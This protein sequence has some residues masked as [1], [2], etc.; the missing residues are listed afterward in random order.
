MIC[1][2]CGNKTQVTNSRIQKRLNRIWRRRRCLVC[3]AIFTTEEM[4]DLRTSLSVRCANGPVAPF[5]RDKL[6]I[7]I[8]RS[9]GHRTSSIDDAG[10]LTATVIAILLHDATTA[11]IGPADIIR[12][13][14]ATLHRFDNVAAV[15]YQAY[16][17]Q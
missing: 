6:F 17:R 3:N 15:Q 1:I 4:A 2:Y 14:L 11:A 8:L 5:S 12:T 9:V 13:V 7:S 16:H 10:A